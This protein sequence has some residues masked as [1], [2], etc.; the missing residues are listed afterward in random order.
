MTLFSSPKIVVYITVF[1]V[2]PKS[3]VFLPIYLL[4][5]KCFGDIVWLSWIKMMNSKLFEGLRVNGLS[6]FLSLL[7]FEYLCKYINY[8][9]PSYSTICTSKAFHKWEIV[10]KSCYV[11]LIKMFL[12]SSY[13]PQPM[14][15]VPVS[16]WEWPVPRCAAQMQWPRWMW[17]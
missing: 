14:W 8:I 4:I 9:T 11:Q 15:R 3:V 16:L 6:L 1:K 10:N 5:S 7:H 17:R 2:I 12:F 13:N